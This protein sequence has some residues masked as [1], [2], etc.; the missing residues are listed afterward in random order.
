ML[1]MPVIFP[2]VNS[3]NQKIW[4]KTVK[5]G[6]KLKIYRFVPQKISV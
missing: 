3:K 6:Q 1:I 5:N 4:Q 2:L